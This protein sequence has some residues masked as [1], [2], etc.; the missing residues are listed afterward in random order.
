MRPRFSIAAL[1]T[2]SRGGAAFALDRFTVC[3]ERTIEAACEPPYCAARA[4]A[5][6]PVDFAR[7]RQWPGL[8]TQPRHPV[9]GVLSGARRSADALSAAPSRVLS[10]CP[11]PTATPSAAMSPVVPTADAPTAELG[12]GSTSGPAKISAKTIRILFMLSP[13]KTLLCGERMRERVHYSNC[14]L[15]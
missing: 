2:A 5:H 12:F 1:A 4:P 3:G 14:I 10:L 11:R 6:D 7:P 13:L 9:R 15:V 8:T